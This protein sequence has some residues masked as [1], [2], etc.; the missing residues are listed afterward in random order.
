[1]AFYTVN[2]NLPLGNKLISGMNKVREGKFILEDILGSLNQM[3][4]AQVSAALGFNEANDH[5]I[6]AAAK[7]ELASDI[8]GELVGNAALA[9]M[10]AQF[11]G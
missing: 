8:G 7:A 2:P 5:E 6:A 1:M 11:N 3:S 10:L 4:N 9:Q